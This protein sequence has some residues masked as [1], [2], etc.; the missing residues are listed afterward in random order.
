[1]ITLYRI[2]YNYMKLELRHL[3]YF[4]AVAD[5]LSFSRA[6]DREGIPQS[7]LSQQIKVLESELEVKLFDRSKHPIQLTF[8]G[9]AFLEEARSTLLQLEQAVRHAQRIHIG[10]TGNLTIGFTSSIANSVLPEILRT[11]REQKSEIRLTLKEEK[12]GA[13]MQKLRDRQIDIIFFYQYQKENDESDLE[14]MGIEQESLVLVL[15]KMHPLNAKSTIQFSDLIDEEFIMPL[16]QVQAGLNEQIYLLCSQTGFIPKVAQEAIFMVT[17]LGMVA[18][19]LGISILPSSVQ[20]LQRD[21][22]VY[23]PIQEQ[24]QI[25][26]LTT[27]WRS[28]NLSIVLQKFLDVT[29]AKSPTSPGVAV[30]G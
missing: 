1:M 24:T 20:S 28:D 10:E 4:I 18:G 13:L 11:F 17:I 5:E 26:Q 14:F 2:N 3:Q 12:S 6:A 15:P 9:Q 22:V 27:A 16:H 7:R 25:T 23:R 8:A 19:G 29:R 21:G 30:H